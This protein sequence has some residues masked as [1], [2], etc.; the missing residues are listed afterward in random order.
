MSNQIDPE[1]SAHTKPRNKANMNQP[2]EEF[3]APDSSHSTD[4]RT[5]EGEKQPRPPHFSDKEKSSK[6]Q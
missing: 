6:N 1:E 3:I 2:Q 5:E 4:S